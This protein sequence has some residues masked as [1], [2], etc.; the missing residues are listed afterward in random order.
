MS[1]REGF[2]RKAPVHPGSIDD[3][4]H[5]QALL[6]KW[7]A[8]INLV[9]PGTLDAFWT[10]HALDSAQLVPLVPPDT[11]VIADFGSGAGFPAIALAIEAKHARTDWHVH[12]MESAGKKASFLKTVIRELGLEA[13]VHR[14][15]IEATGTL[16]ADL[17]TARAFAPLPRLLP[18]ARHHLADDG[19]LLLLKGEGI[20]T[21][22][23]DARED[24]SFKLQ[25]HRSL[26]D[27]AGCIALISGLRPN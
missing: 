13:T 5:W 14:T 18:M 27:E 1:S 23:A 26:T 24:W 4:A 21:E 17:V 10:R 16:E 19:T 22:V 25:K 20:E 7:N 11:R 9:A 6:R 12:L 3:Y 15:R 2:A 8:R